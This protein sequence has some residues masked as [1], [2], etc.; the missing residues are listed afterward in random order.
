MRMSK[1]D[2]SNTNPAVRT[3]RAHV[4]PRTAS[5]P[6]KLSAWAGAYVGVKGGL[7]AGSVIG[8]IGGPIGAGVGG[9]VGGVVGGIAGYVSGARLAEWA[10]DRAHQR[11][12][13]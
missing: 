10:F 7:S 9:V 11:L 6:R 13:P 8:G 12:K 3:V 1:D 4:R 5:S 2:C